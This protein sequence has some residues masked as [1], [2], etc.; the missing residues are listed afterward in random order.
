MNDGC[1]SKQVI[2]IGDCQ[3]GTT[4]SINSPIKRSVV[5][6]ISPKRKR[7][8]SICCFLVD[9]AARLGRHQ[10]RLWLETKAY[11]LSYRPVPFSTEIPL[12]NRPTHSTPQHAGTTTLFQSPRAPV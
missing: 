1:C 8:L 12:N 6:Q 4:S 7:P 10:A 3:Y 2:G 5:K 9:Y 11:A